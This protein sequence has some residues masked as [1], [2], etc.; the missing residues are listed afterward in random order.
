MRQNP[1]HILN[2]VMVGSFFRPLIAYFEGFHAFQDEKR[3]KI[4]I[5][6]SAIRKTF[7][8]FILA[9]MINMEIGYEWPKKL[10]TINGKFFIHYTDGSFIKVG[11]ESVKTSKIR[12]NLVNL[13]F[14]LLSKSKRRSIDT[15]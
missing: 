9:C 7:N 4:L 1:V 3:F 14:P 8:F 13:I 15:S 11:R 2:C 12:Q 6:F 10:P 5:L